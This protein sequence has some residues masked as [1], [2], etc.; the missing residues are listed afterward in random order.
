MRTAQTDSLCYKSCGPK[1][2]KPRLSGG[3]EV[4]GGS[5]SRIRE[6]QSDGSRLCIDFRR[7]GSGVAVDRGAR[8][9]CAPAVDDDV[10]GGP[11]RGVG[12]FAWRNF[13]LHALR[14]FGAGEVETER[15]AVTI[16]ERCAV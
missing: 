15:I 3:G 9:R 5:L 16:L 4:Y 11:P 13:E 2:A 1:R 8:R 6:I 7:G 10:D 14:R 12:T